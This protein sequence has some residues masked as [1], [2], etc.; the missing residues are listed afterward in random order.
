MPGRDDNSIGQFATL[1]LWTARK[2]GVPVRTSLKAVEARLTTTHH[3]TLSAGD[4]EGLAF[5]YSA[6][7]KDG[8]NIH[9]ELNGGGPGGRAGSPGPV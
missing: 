3:F 7:F 9:Y 5:V 2:H 8:P 4:K 1:A 6:W